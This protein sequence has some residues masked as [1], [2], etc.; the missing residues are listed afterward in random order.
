MT[1]QQESLITVSLVGRAMLLN[2]EGAVPFG[3]LHK[4]G[5]EILHELAVL[6]STRLEM[7]CQIPNLTKKKCT[8]P[9]TSG[10]LYAIVYGPSESFRRV[11][12]HLQRH[13]VYLQD[14]TLRSCSTRYYNSHRLCQVEEP[15]AT[16]L[17]IEVSHTHGECVFGDAELVATPLDPFSAIESDKHTDEA[18]EPPEL[19]TKLLR[20]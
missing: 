4:P 2:D 1:F 6:A 13:G 15:S 17:N 11:G 14:P 3:I 8:T 5:A 12:N 20:Y 9:K 18:D 19:K 16:A 10:K 7:F